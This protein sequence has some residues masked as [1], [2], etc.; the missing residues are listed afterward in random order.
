VKSFCVAGG[1]FQPTTPLNDLYRQAQALT[2]DFASFAR[3]GFLLPFA[4]PLALSAR[5]KSWPI[6]AA[7]GAVLVTSFFA[8][9]ASNCPWKALL[10][11]VP[12]GRLLRRRHRPRP[13]PAAR[14]AARAEDALD[15]PHRDAHGVAVAIWP[16]IAAERP[17]YGTRPAPNAMNEPAPGVFDLIRKHTTPDDRI[18][19]NGNPSCTSR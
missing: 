12:G 1:V 11:H 17:A 19:T 3:M 7:A 8:V 9:V 16:R 6:L 14:R 15:A 4:A 18:V 2:E 13:A 10:Q 5:R